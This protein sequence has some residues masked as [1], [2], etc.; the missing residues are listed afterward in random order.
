MLG[1]HNGVMGK[2]RVHLKAAPQM[3]LTSAVPKKG[4]IPRT[5]FGMPASKKV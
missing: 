1:S 3:N 5:A 2:D 4:V